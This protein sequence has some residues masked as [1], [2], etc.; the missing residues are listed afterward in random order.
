[1][2]FKWIVDP[3]NNNKYERTYIHKIKI[4]HPQVVSKLNYFLPFADHIDINIYIPQNKENH[5]GF[6]KKKK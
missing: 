3:K 5:T 2:T 4:T 6:E 1:M